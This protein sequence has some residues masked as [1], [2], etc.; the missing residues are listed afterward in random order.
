MKRR[1]TVLTCLLC[2]TA[3][4]ATTP[5]ES[6]FPATPGA[7]YLA[8][9]RWAAGNKSGGPAGNEAFARWLG[10]PLV[11]AEDFTPTER[12]DSLEGGGWQ[13]GPWSAWKQAVAGRRL[14]LSIPLLPGGWDR[15]GPTQGEGKGVKVSLEAGAAGDYNAHFRRLAENLVKYDLADSLLRLGWEF[16]GGWYTWRI[17]RNPAAYAGYWRQIV[18]TMRAV[19][20][21]EKLQFCYNPASVWIPYKADDAWPGD[22][23]VDLVGL[24]LYDDS[25]LKDTYPLPKDCSPEVAAARRK[26]VWEQ[27]LLGG[28]HGLRYWSEFARRHGKPFCVPEWGVDNR[29]DK[30]GGGDN[31]WFVER[32]HAW[33]TDPANNVYFHC[34]FDVQAGDGHHQ[35]SPGIKGDEQCEFPL[36]SARFRALFGAPSPI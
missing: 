4:G 1:C 29:A 28:D 17:D 10:R 2:L 20:C 34:Y 30:H 16:N 12:W 3:L 32:M 22:E 18:T 35:L 13:L 36:A 15:Q 11:W 8:V 23:Y 24:D 9:Y 21:A 33:L 14:I 27:A 31:P 19:K 26:V 7:P 25:W 6:G 5:A